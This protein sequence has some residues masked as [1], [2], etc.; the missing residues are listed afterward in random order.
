MNEL[1]LSDMGIYAGVLALVC[2]FL[3]VMLSLKKQSAKSLQIGLTAG[4]VGVFLGAIGSYASARAL[5][6]EVTKQAD[7]MENEAGDDEMGGGGGGGRGGFGGGG[8][9]GRGGFGGGGGGRGGRGGFQPSPT[10]ELTTLV[11][12]LDLL[13]GDVKIELA[14]DQRK[15][16][17]ALLDGIKSA[18][19]ID[20]DTAQDML[21]ELN[22]KLTDEQKAKLEAVSLPRTRGSFGR[23]GGGGDGEAGNPFT[24]DENAS[25]AMESLAGRL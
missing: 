6:Y 18:E 14:Y 3:V 16:V 10:R 1:N 15:A 19:A 12:E 22:G 8:G 25:K 9:G 21:D 11:R 13:T 5:K 7:E 24:S 4:L 20:D 2:V 17:K 23:G